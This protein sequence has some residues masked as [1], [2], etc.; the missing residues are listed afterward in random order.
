VTEKFTIV[1]KTLA[2]LEEILARE[3]KQIGGEKIRTVRRAVT[4][5]GD[6]RIL[7]KA[8]YEM[9]TAL[10]IL[11]QIHAFTFRN[12]DDFYH[13]CREVNW[14]EQM[15]E[16]NTFAVYSTVNHSQVFKN[17]MFASLK[18]KDAI[19]D[20][21]RQ[22]RG[23]RPNVNTT[24]PDIIIA[25]YISENKATLS[26]DSSGEP[27][28]K[29][30]Y[31]VGQTKAPLNEV[32][33][34]GMILLSGWNEHSVFIDP[35]CGSGTLPVEAA[36]IASHTPPGFFRKSFAFEKWSDFD[37]ALFKEIAQEKRIQPPQKNIYASDLSERN[38]GIAKANARNAG[39]YKYIQFAVSNFSDLKIET[40]KGTLIINPPYGER[41]KSMELENLYAMMGERLKHQYPGNT[42]WILSSS[43]ELLKK[44]GLKHNQRVE[45]YNGPI[46]C[47]FRKY[48]LFEG[49]QNE[50]SLF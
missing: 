34:A 25:L 19:V 44:V 26:L 46:Q 31:R 6:Q 15:D 45:L 1:A 38:I 7:Y 4:F 16:N 10:R 47:E 8:N 29:R 49:K 24:H 3:V 20:L 17:S 43:K 37:N 30:G 42:A 48:D 5:E 22:K 27:L 28:Y 9:R 2:G 35:M 40:N 32:L 41:L 23:R 39:V 36:L 18:A 50:N 11:K 14:P 21:F 12:A 13:H 33:A